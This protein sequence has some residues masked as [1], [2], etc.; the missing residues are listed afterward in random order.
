MT[1]TPLNETHEQLLK[2]GWDVVMEKGFHHA[3][4]NDITSAAGVPKGSFYYYFKSKEDFGLALIQYYSCDYLENLERVRDM[5]DLS[6]Y[7][8]L[9]RLFRTD[10]D[11]LAK[12]EYKGG[13][14]VE[15]IGHEL[16]GQVESFRLSVQE[17]HTRWLNSL[18]ALF[19]EG[20]EDGSITK[21]VS[22][23]DLVQFTRYCIEGAMAK[24]KIEKTQAPF[25]LLETL[26]FERLI[27]A[28]H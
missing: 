22:A 24:A 10:M 21:D 3:S 4:I 27:K 6:G 20:Q 17:I 26:C 9:L 19:E 15:K 14:I 2:V 18:I 28:A 12:K 11:D 13:C 1:S 8:K 7:E 23:H 5:S 16:A 25:I